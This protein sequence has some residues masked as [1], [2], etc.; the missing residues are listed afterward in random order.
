VTCVVSIEDDPSPDDLRAIQ[1]GLT[2]HALPVTRVPGFQCV[3]VL[4]RDDEATLVGGAV[5]AVNW[6]WLHVAL[7]WVSEARRHTGLGTRLMD[8]LEEVA[9]RRG[10]THAHL[11]TFIYQAR[12]FYERRG[13][14]V[15]AT[16]DDYPPGHQR[17][18]MAK[19][20][21]ETATSTRAASTNRPSGRRAARSR[22]RRRDGPG[23]AGAGPRR[24]SRP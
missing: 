11:D 18:F 14:R 3:A 7:V 23:C 19:R 16:L 24:R 9:A 15:F 5:G 21:A 1:D 4:A 20:L 2:R 8:D 17:F 6:N 22:R 13:Y 12:P 10:C